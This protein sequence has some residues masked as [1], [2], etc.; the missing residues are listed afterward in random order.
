VGGSN[1]AERRYDGFAASLMAEI[2]SDR[3]FR[4]IG[5]MFHQGDEK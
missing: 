2:L 3:S 5:I 4:L 1:L